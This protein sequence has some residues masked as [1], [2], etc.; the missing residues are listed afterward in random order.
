MT[1]LEAIEQANETVG[2]RSF[3][4]ANLSEFN[5]FLESFEFEDYPCHVVV[6][7]ET[8][9]EWYNNRIYNVAVIQG[10]VLKRID[11]DTTNFKA[12]EIEA[13]HIAPM[14]AKAK[15][16]IREMVESDVTNPEVERV[17]SSIKPEYG[18]L[19]ASLF[20]VSYTLNWPIAEGIC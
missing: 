11:E 6:P 2:I 9:Q 7:F 13:L 1:I 3:R 10:W 5:K 4:F 8:R 15:N 14:R 17:T 12:A 16:L 20:G 19:T 18:Q